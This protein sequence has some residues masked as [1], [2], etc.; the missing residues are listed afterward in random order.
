M[1]RRL[2]PPDQ[3]VV[4]DFEGT[5]VAAAA[6]DTVACALLAAGVDGFRTTPV[7]GSRRAPHCLIGQCFDCLVRIDGVPGQRACLLPVSPGMRV[8][9]MSGVPEAE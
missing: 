9:R 7:S 6:G 5:D 2:T 3:V 4:I 8:E 1:F